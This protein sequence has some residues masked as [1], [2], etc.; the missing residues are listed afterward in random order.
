[1]VQELLPQFVSEGEG[2]ITDL[3]SY[4][5][6]EGMVYYFHAGMPIYCHTEKD[7]RNFRMF[8]SQL[9][10]NGNCSQVDIVRAFG[11]SAISMKRWV[12]IYREEGSAGFFKQPRKRGSH[13]LTPEVLK[14]LQDLL[15]QGMS[16][17][18]AAKQMNVKLDTLSKAIRSGRLMGPVKKTTPWEAAK[19]SE[20]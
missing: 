16:R 12:K 6:R 4:Q 20:V 2:Q 7:I 8:T 10:V 19:A 13:V 1:M 11:V 18:E 5:K 9:V 17:S 15:S 14:Q 3:L